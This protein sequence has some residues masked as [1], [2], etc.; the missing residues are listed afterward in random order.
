[1]CLGMAVQ[2]QKIALGHFVQDPP[3]ATAVTA[4]DVE[5]LLPGIAVVK[6]E[7]RKRAGKA[8]HAARATFLVHQPSFQCFAGR[9]R[10]AVGTA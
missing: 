3:Q 4:R 1:M 9:A 2:A 7:C 5:R 8:A 10:R 6:A